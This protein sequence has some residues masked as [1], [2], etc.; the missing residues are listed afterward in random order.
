M[1]IH[2]KLRIKLMESVAVTA[3]VAIAGLRYSLKRKEVKFFANP[4]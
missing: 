1:K 2:A 4:K 3:G